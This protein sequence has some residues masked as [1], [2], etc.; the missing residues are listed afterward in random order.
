MIFSEFSYIDKISFY[1]IVGFRN[2]SSGS[3]ALSLLY[4]FTNPL[5]YSKY[6]FK[7]R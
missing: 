1:R 7:T 2:L 5:I 3:V 4:K 6:R